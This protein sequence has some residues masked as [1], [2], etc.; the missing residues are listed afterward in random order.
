MIG[1]LILVTFPALAILLI[2]HLFFYDSAA[3]VKA[4]GS[5]EKACPRWLSVLTT[6]VVWT[7]IVNAVIFAI[8]VQLGIL[9]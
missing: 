1:I 7:L 5:P 2:L 4:D 6:I 9:R 8:L 3:G